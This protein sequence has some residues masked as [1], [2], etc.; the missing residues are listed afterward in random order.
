M[1]PLPFPFSLLRP[2][3]ER[4]FRP[5]FTP[6]EWAAFESLTAMIEP[7]KVKTFPPGVDI[8]DLK[9]L[10]GANAK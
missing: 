8:Y 6:E 5:R 1:P 10:T 3:K 2:Q 7:A 4:Y 9:R